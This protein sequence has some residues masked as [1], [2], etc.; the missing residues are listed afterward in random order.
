MPKPARESFVEKK[1]APPI[2]Q[3][4]A[5]C[6]DQGR[7][8]FTSSRP[9]GVTERNMAIDTPRSRRKIA[10][11]RARKVRGGIDAPNPSIWFQGRKSTIHRRASSASA[12]AAGGTGEAR[13]PAKTASRRRFPGH[14]GGSS[15]VPTS[16]GGRPECD[17]PNRS[18]RSEAAKWIT[19]PGLLIFE[20][21][22]R[23][24]IAGH[25]L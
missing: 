10:R 25:Q 3:R 24:R 21:R 1:F 14:E 12:A 22:W 7:K 4:A 23:G 19:P 15:G 18:R 17:L 9:A 13:Q 5:A 16:D 11:P 6:L 8:M 2:T 20:F